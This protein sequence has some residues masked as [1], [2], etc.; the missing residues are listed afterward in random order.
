MNLKIYILLVL[1]LSAVSV[2]AMGGVPPKSIEILAQ[3]RDQNNGHIGLTFQLHYTGKQAVSVYTSHLPWGTK[4][5]L[6]LVSVCLN[7]P[8]SLVPPV[9]YFD[10]PGPNQLTL[11]PGEVLTGSIDLERRFPTLRDCLQRSDALVFWSY[12]LE[13][14]SSDA[15]FQRLSGGVLITR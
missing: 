7:G 6:V 10:D 11:Q 4:D 13:P 14:I 2:N 9:D 12:Q 3:R 8:K 15:P 5:N 1:C